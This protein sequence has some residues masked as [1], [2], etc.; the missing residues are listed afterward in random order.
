MTCPGRMT[1]VRWNPFTAIRS[2]M[3]TFTREAMIDR[4]SPARTVY[5]RPADDDTV[6]LP[7]FLLESARATSAPVAATT[8]SAERT[9]TNDLDRRPSRPPAR[10]STTF[11]ITGWVSDRPSRTFTEILG[12]SVK[13]PD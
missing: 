8:E 2:D 7:E 9:A 3:E 6:A 1:V 12:P 5:V 13:M 10:L 11:R 4:P